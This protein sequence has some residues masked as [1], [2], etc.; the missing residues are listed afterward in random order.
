MSEAVQGLPGT[1]RVNVKGLRERLGLNQ[2]EL[3]DKLHVDER[4][5][6]RWE[7]GTSKPSPMAMAHMR[8]LVR[9]AQGEGEGSGQRPSASTQAPASSH[10]ENEGVSVSSA[11][12]LP[13]RRIPTF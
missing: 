12:T 4:T 10:I 3:A 2:A 6:R 7:H 1:S 13:R 8:S 9:P 5:I 11:P